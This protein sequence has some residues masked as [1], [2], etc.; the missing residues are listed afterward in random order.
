[1]SYSRWTN[2]Y[3]YTYWQTAPEDVKEDRNTARFCICVLAG[4]D[5]IFSSKDLREN[6]SNCLKKVR[7]DDKYASNEEIRELNNYMNSFIKDVDNDYPL[8]F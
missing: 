8:K 1:M 3:W 7:M 2:S 5:F 6:R 4:K